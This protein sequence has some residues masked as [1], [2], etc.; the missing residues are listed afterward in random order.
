MKTRQTLAPLLVISALAMLAGCTRSSSTAIPTAPVPSESSQRVAQ[1]GRGAFHSAM[2]SIDSN[3]VL[4]AFDNGIS[5]LC[6]CDMNEIGF[7][8]LAEAPLSLAFFPNG[9]ELAVGTAQGNIL[10]LQFSIETGELSQSARPMVSASQA[11]NDPQDP[12]DVTTM[13]LSPDGRTLAALS[14]TSQLQAWNL[15]EDQPLFH[16]L[17]YGS[18]GIILSPNNQY[19]LAGPQLLDL[20]TGDLLHEFEGLPLNFLPDGDKV[21][22]HD[23]NISWKSSVYEIFDIATGQHSQTIQLEEREEEEPYLYSSQDGSLILEVFDLNPTLNL[24]EA[25][26]GELIHSLSAQA[27]WP[28]NLDYFEVSESGLVFGQAIMT[29]PGSE[30]WIVKPFLVD[31][32]Q[33]SPEAFTIDFGMPEDFAYYYYHQTL[34]SPDGKYILYNRGDWL[35]QVEVSTHEVRYLM[36]NLPAGTVGALAFNTDGNG[37]AIGKDTG[38]IGTY[39]LNYHYVTNLYTPGTALYWA[40]RQPAGISGLAFLP[41]G[42]SL[43]YIANPGWLSLWNFAESSERTINLD[44]PPMELFGL[45]LAPDD[46][47]MA[48]G[49][50]GQ[51]VHVWNDPLETEPRATMLEDSSPVGSV[52]YSPDGKVLASGDEK[53]FIRLWDLTSGQLLKTLKGHSAW[54]NGLAFQQDGERLFSISEDGTARVWRVSDGSQETVLELGQA[55][56][57]LALDPRGQVLALGVQDGR[58]YLWS[59]LT[60]D[61]LGSLGDGSSGVT[62]LAFTDD[63]NRLAFGLNNGL[64]QIWQIRND[65]G[66]LVTFSQILPLPSPVVTGCQVEG[67]T[68]FTNTISSQAVYKAGEIYDLAW[69]VPASGD[70]ASQESNA[71]LEPVG[72]VEA[73]DLRIID[74]DL[75]MIVFS[76]RVTMPTQAGSFEAAWKIVLPNTEFVITAHLTTVSSGVASTLPAPLYYLD[77][78]AIMRL[79]LD[80]VTR[81]QIVEAPVQCFDISPLDGSLAFLRDDELILADDTGAGQH[82]LLSIAGCPSWSTDG[83]KIA[84][85]LNGV[86]IVTVADGVVQTL[87]TDQNV[88]S[89]DRRVYTGILGWSPF[90]NKLVANV[91]YWQGNESILIDITSTYRSGLPGSGNIAWSRDGVHVYQGEGYFNCML[92]RQPSIIR[93]DVTSGESE[94]LLGDP[95]GGWTDLRGGLA[96]LDGTDGRLYFLGIRPEANP[97]LIDQPVPL[98]SQPARMDP[99]DHGSLEYDETQTF[100]GVRGALWWKDGSVVVLSLAELELEGT[101]QTLILARPF[102]STQ[103]LFL[104]IIGSNLRWGFLP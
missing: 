58:V 15:S 55:G 8:P 14:G 77:R 6:S 70:C 7:F 92:G 9:V 75:G 24:Y 1:I 87:R 59:P 93:T 72:V 76:A 90:S 27:T 82:I 73:D 103:P 66:G 64:V 69:L 22:F 65:E 79:E 21:I 43:A 52:A 41:D 97:C 42:K 49:G 88:A 25:A 38:E 13:V 63:G 84:Y 96:P 28:D 44:D 39:D 19:M 71:R 98:V 12:F 2:Y 36:D 94:T 57:S 45:A 34:F 40:R 91:D 35:A 20:E 48:V 16:E 50:Y 47:G 60:N 30:I 80:G 74:G 99:I 104:P 10:F 17:I 32:S 3:Y 89:Q 29:E 67:G 18:G 83:T 23:L 4:A 33:T 56:S 61:W 85:P 5:I 101:T 102:T 78:G 54:V 46:L 53:G 62:A 95:W 31:L 86:K 11:S 68:F 100:D 51:V 81:S 37:L 26:T